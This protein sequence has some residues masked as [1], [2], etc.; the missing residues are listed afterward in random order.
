MLLCGI[1]TLCNSCKHSSKKINENN[2]AVTLKLFETPIE[3]RNLLVDNK[4]AV[5]LENIYTADCNTCS[6]TKMHQKITIEIPVGTHTFM[7]KNQEEFKSWWVNRQINKDD[8]GE[9]IDLS[10][11]ALY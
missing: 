6:S 9:E 10:A 4:P 8:D 11:T 3:E 1:I 5:I 2:V 7:I